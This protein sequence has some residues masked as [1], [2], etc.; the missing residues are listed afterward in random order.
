MKSGCVA[1]IRST[2]TI[3]PT[4][5]VPRP[6]RLASPLLSLSSYVVFVALFSFLFFLLILFASFFLCFSLSAPCQTLLQQRRRKPPKRAK[7][8]PALLHGGLQ[9]LRRGVWYFS[10]QGKWPGGSGS[11]AEGPRSFLHCSPPPPKLD[12]PSSAAALLQTLRR[13]LLLIML[14]L[15]GASKILWSNWCVC[16]LRPARHGRE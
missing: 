13:E 12:S 4:I 6:A 10:A 16:L 3:A 8:A 14:Q 1:A 7:T 2:S 9:Q 11:D 5:A 15:Q